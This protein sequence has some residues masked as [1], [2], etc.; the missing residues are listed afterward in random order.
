MEVLDQIREICSVGHPTVKY[1]KDRELGKMLTTK[2]STIG[3]FYSKES[4][5]HFFFK[6]GS[7]V[8]GTVFLAFNKYNSERVAVKVIDLAKQPRKE[9][10]LMELRVRTS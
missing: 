3:V 7:G 1:S 5:H 4:K 9:M 2:L 10:I 8:A 6:L